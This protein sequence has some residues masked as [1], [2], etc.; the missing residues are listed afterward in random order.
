MPQDVKIFVIG[1]GNP[2]RLDDG[3]G[4]AFASAIADL[5]ISGV[6]VD[7]DYQLAV[8]DAHAIA[9]CDYAVFADA[10]VEGSEPFFFKRVEPEA[11]EGFSSHIL[12]P[13]AVMHLAQT[14]F[15]SHVKGYILGIRGYEFDAFGEH[16]SAKAEANL[17]KALAFLEPVL[18]E[19]SFEKVE[20]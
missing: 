6:S 9:E 20:R 5:N 18:R 12:E 15:H 16:L 14:L 8:E 7:S 2:G 11:T 3:L 13:P 19:R 1:Y 4:P 10:S 17:A